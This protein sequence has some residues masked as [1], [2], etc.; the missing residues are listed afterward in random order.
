MMERSRHV[1]VLADHSKL[2]FRAPAVVAPVSMVTTLVTDADAG[3]EML[4]QI[5]A[6]SLQVL[7]ARKHLED[8]VGLLQETTLRPGALH[9]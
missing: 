1:I 6:D 8:H 7:L 4:D 2:G 9:T 5:Q 3:Q